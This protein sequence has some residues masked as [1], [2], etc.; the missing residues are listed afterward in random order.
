VEIV[1]AAGI[2]LAVVFLAEGVFYLVQAYRKPEERRVR[3][4]LRTLAAGGYQ[5]EEVSILRETVL[6]SIPWFNRLL[7]KVPRILRVS[8][9]LEQAGAPY[10]AGVYFALSALLGPVGYIGAT[11]LH[12]P[13]AAKVMCAAAG[14]AAP[15]LYLY[16]KKQ[17]RMQKFER[18]LP[19]TLEMI[20]R[21]LK[22]GHA[23]TG[24][25]QMAADEFEDPAGTEFGKTLEEINFGIA[26]PQA[27]KGLAERVDC[28]D[29]KFFVIAVLI[30]RETGGNLAEIMENLAYLIRERFKL[31]GKVEVL[32]SEGKF[33]AIILV[34]IPFLLFLY[35]YFTQPDYI[36][37][38]Y[39]DPMGRTMVVGALVMMAI[40][41]LIMKR[42]VKIKI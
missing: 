40:G 41:T 4:R 36:K 5:E 20:A 34:V 18:Q 3:R 8:W 19:E 24:G 1:I 39:T 31:H 25:L 26:V 42:M 10:P 29:L 21:A 13:L 14:V 12:L 17:R 23:F 28:P 37:L 27:L 35:F 30:Q 38:L 33:S 32:A 9:L 11:L 16:V 6:S 22:A 7:F 2:F 15:F